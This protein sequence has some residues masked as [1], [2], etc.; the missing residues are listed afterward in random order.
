MKH[1]FL[2]TRPGQKLSVALKYFNNCLSCWWQESNWKN[3]RLIFLIDLKLKR[4]PDERRRRSFQNIILT[5]CLLQVD[6]SLQT[7]LRTQ[8]ERQVCSLKTYSTIYQD[9]RFLEAFRAF[10]SEKYNI[11]TSVYESVSKSQFTVVTVPVSL[12][13]PDSEQ[14]AP[15]AL[16]QSD[17]T[18]RK[19]RGAETRDSR[20]KKKNH[21]WATNWF[22]HLGVSDS[23]DSVPHVLCHWEEHAG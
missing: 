19:S 10:H 9:L 8:W 12:S 23:R 11:F 1:D 13:L 15:A 6:S 16:S 17:S 4:F 3:L 21:V 7:P 5:S 22:V 18:S 14:A 20:T 2:L